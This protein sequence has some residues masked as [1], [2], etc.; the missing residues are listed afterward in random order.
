LSILIK[1]RRKETDPK[2]ILTDGKLK[3]K[4]LLRGSCWDKIEN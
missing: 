3:C 1:N 2:V 4:M